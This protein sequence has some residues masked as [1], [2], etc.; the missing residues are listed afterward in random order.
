M[1]ED[2]EAELAGSLKE[3]SNNEN[4]TVAEETNADEA[5]TEVSKD[6]NRMEIYLKDEQN[7]EAYEETMNIDI[8]NVNTI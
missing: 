1:I 4:L 2:L 3:N 8:E 5:I 6:S 7:T